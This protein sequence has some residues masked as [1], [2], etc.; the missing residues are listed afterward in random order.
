MT[1][2]ASLEPGTI[3]GGDL[4][5][6]RRIARGGMG[7]VYEAEQTSTGQKRALKVMDPALVADPKMRARFEQEAKIAA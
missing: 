7:A 6:V 3:F 4:R 2:P 1:D 5:V